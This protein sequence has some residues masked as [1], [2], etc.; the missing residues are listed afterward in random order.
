MTPHAFLESAS[1]GLVTTPRELHLEESLENFFD[2]GAFSKTVCIEIEGRRIAA[3]VHFTDTV[4]CVVFRALGAM[5]GYRVKSRSKWLGLGDR[6]LP[7]LSETLQVSRHGI[8]TF[9]QAATRVKTKGNKGKPGSMS[10]DICFP[11]APSASHADQVV[12][13][14]SHT[15]ESVN[16]TVSEA[17]FV[18]GKPQ[19]LDNPS[20]VTSIESRVSPA[21]SQ[22]VNE[23]VLPLF[24]GRSYKCASNMHDISD[25]VS[26]MAESCS[27]ISWP[28]CCDSSLNSMNCGEFPIGEYCHIERYTAQ[29]EVPT[30]NSGE[31]TQHA[32]I[33]LSCD[34]E[35]EE[36]PHLGVTVDSLNFAHIGNR[37]EPE[38]I[39]H[40]PVVLEH[41]ET[42]AVN[43]IQRIDLVQTFSACQDLYRESSLQ[44][45]QPSSILTV[46]S[47]CEGPP[48]SAGSWIEGHSSTVELW[49]VLPGATKAV[50]MRVNCHNIVGDV[51]ISLHLKRPAN[52]TSNVLYLDLD[53]PVTA[54]SGKVLR[55]KDRGILGGMKRMHSRSARTSPRPDQ[56][57]IP[58][59]QCRGCLSTHDPI[60]DIGGHAHA[61]VMNWTLTHS[62][63]GRLVYLSQLAEYPAHC[64]DP[65]PTGTLQSDVRLR[66]N[67]SEP[68][69]AATSAR[70]LLILTHVKIL[71]SAEERQVVC[72]EDS[73]AICH[74]P[75]TPKPRALRVMDV[76]AGG[77]GG[78]TH[79]ARHLKDL[80]VPISTVAYI[81][82]SAS[83]AETHM[84]NHGGIHLQKHQLPVSGNMKLGQRLYWRKDVTVGSLALL[85]SHTHAN[86]WT[87]PYPCPPWSRAGGQSGFRTESGRLWLDVS[88]ADCSAGPL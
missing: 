32:S 16:I 57:D 50:V 48:A 56:P 27:D 66:I 12:L 25:E 55:L 20:L 28:L 65:N 53:I 36:T 73:A 72:L 80:Q 17:S 85:H 52:C 84:R 49:V 59:E 2:L 70:S 61:C 41:C 18:R 29:P 22:R 5:S 82:N 7:M 60:W 64:E 43:H 40:P 8:M 44:F 38:P 24:I 75:G 62:H 15:C 21:L 9:N 30:L 68:L 83:A 51:A 19:D 69:P 45:C 26:A 74:E 58:T 37:C 23:E 3:S 39:M 77:V 42:A 67:T 13:P 46:C 4:H 81:D 11:C 34:A 14:V 47:E 6:V 71:V 63:S 87:V 10:T 54:L 88:E 79:A 35:N 31:Q 78:W 1:F 86:L 33:A 76:F